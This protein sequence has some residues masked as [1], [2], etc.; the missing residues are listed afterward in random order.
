MTLDLNSFKV[1]FIDFGLLTKIKEENKIASANY[2]YLNIIQIFK[3]IKN[4]Y[5]NQSFFK[6]ELILLLNDQRYMQNIDP[7]QLKIFKHTGLP[8]IDYSCYFQSL[9]DDKKYSLEEFYTNCIEPIVKNVD[10]Y[11]LTL[12]INE[13]FFSILGFKTFNSKHIDKNTYKIVNALLINA[14]YNNIDGPAE[15]IIYLEGIIDSLN[16]KYISE[17]IVNKIFNLRNGKKKYFFYNIEG[18]LTDIEGKGFK[19]EQPQQQQFMQPYQQQQFIQPYQ[20]Q[21]FI[22]PY[23]QQQFIQPYQQ[24]QFIQ[25]YQQQFIRPRQQQFIQQQQQQFIRQ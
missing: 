18:G 12:F 8:F 22:Q 5:N 10:I 25:P 7:L 3:N 21:Q 9:R 16:G 11:S 14:F 20:Q 23:Q 6:S 19:Y 17:N 13:L 24:Q 4:D 2:H 15:L 1:S